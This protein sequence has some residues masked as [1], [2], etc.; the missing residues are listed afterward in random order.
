V[1]Q[2]P[3]PPPVQHRVRSPSPS[4]GPVALAN[5]LLR[6][7]PVE[8]V[9]LLNRSVTWK[10][11]HTPGVPT[12]PFALRPSASATALASPTRST[13][14]ASPPR[15][16]RSPSPALPCKA[17]PRLT[18]TIVS[19]SRQPS[20][21]V[22]VQGPAL[23]LTGRPTWRMESPSSARLVSHSA[24]QPILLPAKGPVVV[25]QVF[26]RS[27][28]SVPQF[29]SE[30]TAPV[31]LRLAPAATVPPLPGYQACSG[32]FPVA[33]GTSRASSSGCPPQALPG[34]EESE[35][36][37]V[38]ERL[39]VLLSDPSVVA[40]TLQSCFEAAGGSP[41]GSVPCH[42]AIRALCTA[43]TML[44][45]GL[46]S[47]CIS[48]ARWCSLLKRAGIYSPEDPVTLD[49]MREV[50]AQTLGA[51][52]DC[53]APKQLLRSM[54][55]VARAEPRLKDRYESF[56]FRAKGALGKVYRCRH[57]QSQTFVEVRQIRK[58]KASAP[59]DFIRTSLQR[60]T[61]LQHPCMPRVLDCLEDFRNF[62]VVSEPV[63]GTEVMDFMQNSFVRGNSVS[64]ACVA[65][66]L[67]QVLDALAYCHA[68]TLGP[69][70]HRDLQP[71][72]VLVAESHKDDPS[73]GPAAL[74]AWVTSIGL[75]PLFDLHGLGGSLP[76]ASLPP[77]PENRPELTP[78]ALPSSGS[79]EFLAP[80]CWR[81]DYGPKCDVWSC[82]CLLFLLLTGRPPFLPRKSVAD[83]AKRQGREFGHVVVTLRGVVVEPTGWWCNFGFVW[84]S[85][86][87]Q[88]ENPCMV[89]LLAAAGVPMP[90]TH[91]ALRA[92][93][94]EE[95]DD[96]QELEVYEALA[97]L[98]GP[99]MNPAVLSPSEVRCLAPRFLA[100]LERR[101]ERHHFALAALGGLL[102]RWVQAQL[103]EAMAAIKFTLKVIR[104]LVERE[105]AA[106]E[107]P[108]SAQ[109][110]EERAQFLAQLS[111]A[112]RLGFAQCT[113]REVEIP[114][115]IKALHHFAAANPGSETQ[116]LSL[117]ILAFLC[118]RDSDLPG[119]AHVRECFPAHEL[120]TLMGH[121]SE[122][123]RQANPAK[124][125]PPG[126][127]N[128][129]V[130]PLL[131]EASATQTTLIDC[132]G[133]VAACAESSVLVGSGALHSPALLAALAALG[134]S[135][136]EELSRFAEAVGS[137]VYSLGK[138]W[139]NVEELPFSGSGGYAADSILSQEPDWHLFRSAS[140]AAL[141]LCKRML[142]KDEMARPTAGDCLRHPWLSSWTFNAPTPELP[143]LPETFSALMQS[144]AQ[145]KFFQVLMNVVASE[146]KVGRLGLVHGAFER[147][148][149]S[150]SGYVS[151]QGLQAAL[152]QLGVSDQTSEQA[153]RALDVSGT[154]QIPYTLFIAGCV[155]LV[156]DKL[157]HMLWK[158]AEDVVRQSLRAPRA[159]AYPSMFSFTAGVATKDEEDEELVQLEAELLQV[160]QELLG[161][162]RAL[163]EGRDLQ[164][165]E[166][167]MTARLVS[168]IEGL[169]DYDQS[170]SR[171]LDNL[172]LLLC[173]TLL[174]YMHVGFAL[175]ETGTC[176]A[177]SASDTL[178]KNVLGLCTGT[179]AWW[180][181]GYGLAKGE[182]LGG[183]FGTS[184]FFGSTL[185]TTSS[186]S[187]TPVW[188]C[189]SGSCPS[190][191]AGWFFQW[192]CCTTSSTIVS[193]ALLERAR[194][195]TYSVYAFLMCGFMYPVVVAWTW[196]GGWLSDFLE[197][198]YTDFAGSCVVHVSGGSGAL[199]G[200]LV[201][202]SRHERFERPQ[203]YEPHN[204]P[205]LV[206][207][208]LFL[209]VGWIAFNM[210][211]VAS[212]HTQAGAA[213][214]AQVAVNTVLA[215][216]AGAL[217]VFC[218]RFATTRKYD[219]VGL[220]NGI[221]AGAVSI[222]AGCGNVDAASALAM[223][224]IGGLVYCGASYLLR[225][226]R[227]D[228]PVDASAVHLGCGT[229]GTLAAALFDWGRGLDY[230][231]GRQGWTC[232][233]APDS[234]DGDR[235]CMGGAAP[236][237]VL[238][239]LVFVLCVIAWMCTWS[240][241]IFKLLTSLAGLRI[242][243][244]AGGLDSAELAQK[245]AYSLQDREGPNSWRVLWS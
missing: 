127:W 110:K 204:L 26:Q 104:Q 199:V 115:F 79:P 239:Q 238:V 35:Q 185:L 106:D 87:V 3:A 170:V 18:R 4:G 162:L 189:S 231:H 210:G 222:T 128:Y 139:Q 137:R 37:A 22:R 7:P 227:I 172:W 225:K 13:L 201:L 156:D 60:I 213:L 10:G 242:E 114:F 69:I 221:L 192:A 70:I 138:P 52:R 223:A 102:V 64:E 39:K 105:Q 149:A 182:L 130:L 168:Q 219:V 174:M 17:E 97:V 86:V 98:E 76:S 65:H 141:A 180:S 11:G 234:G 206:L 41:H 77:T 164:E 8:P 157:D 235:V 236:R 193:G 209:W 196:G 103:L 34:G 20:P 215:G 178:V 9:T 101:W 129:W 194:S 36:L 46:P 38:L 133:F 81:K 96:V 50:Q 205:L 68:Q 243:D 136:G 167:G 161:R 159:L 21:R 181:L 99:E 56:E 30:P 151:S 1:V 5:P 66:L 47:T 85:D 24:R 122:E 113:G 73:R 147:V 241:V 188:A 55:R 84:S 111:H 171:V 83:L 93:L 72:C 57:I 203:A 48:E 245:K 51:L 126:P 28:S 230:Y 2:H 94:L 125:L 29:V 134:R 116:A 144:H 23:N 16:L 160:K 150:G 53:F 184:G 131:K 142:D 62:F 220:C 120:W 74:K 158:A 49:Q 233:E 163:D 6:G 95:L 27:A 45:A 190:N 177:V 33:A 67:R 148:D 135:D 169:K 90:E 214:A 82:G 42:A 121:A 88:L 216:S 197:V 152:K 71:E 208:T 15:L 218:V 240:L 175:V 207:G 119:A 40:N 63:E 59:M 202:G 123:F 226:M 212:M 58:D 78:E 117:E 183:F 89:T 173:G 153:L 198:G 92:I 224:S 187:V 176:R 108:K 211:A 112:A 244:E 140:T 146:I 75:Q 12:P 228:D 229:W 100:L 155:D 179:V 109:I 118:G 107:A 80:E 195:S 200:T 237:A 132:V 154:G 61:E 232:L 14:A 186:E 91:G 31:P 145:S 165:V 217:V 143:L 32:E 44:L 25:Q 19:S 54:R 43:H 124:D 191:L 166:P